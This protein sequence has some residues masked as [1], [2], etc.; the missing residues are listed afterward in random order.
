MSWLWK[1]RNGDEC[2]S[3]EAAIRGDSLKTCRKLGEHL[4]ERACVVGYTEDVV[5]RSNDRGPAAMAVE[6][7]CENAIF[8]SDG[9]VLGLICRVSRTDADQ[10]HTKSG[11]VRPHIS[12]Q[13]R[14][15]SPVQHNPPSGS[16]GDVEKA[17]SN[18]RS[19]PGLWK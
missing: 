6:P 8:F 19:D 3:L 11:Q 16:C 12:G 2:L 7:S 18:C 9:V 14:R 1:P 10:S 5:V 17:P 15:A 4:A 13:I